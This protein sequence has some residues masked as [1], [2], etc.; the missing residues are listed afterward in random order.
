FDLSRY[1]RE[2]AAWTDSGVAGRFAVA[3]AGL[4][5][6]DSGVLNAPGLDRARFGVYLGTGE[7]NQNFDALVGLVAAG[8]RPGE[9]HLD[10]VALSSDGLAHYHPGRELAQELHVPSAQVA[11]YFELD[12]P[13][14]ACLTACAAGTQA[15]GEAAELIRHGD[16]DVML[17]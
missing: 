2:P 5:L 4:A 7:G 3:A 17:A 6:D 11:E 13:N 10:A 15:L 8:Y 9:D 1:V 12:G 16:A 14:Y